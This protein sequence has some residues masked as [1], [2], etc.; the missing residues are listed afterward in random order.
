MV[1]DGWMMGAAVG[2]AIALVYFMSKTVIDNFDVSRQVKKNVAVGTTSVAAL[3]GVWWIFSQP[4]NPPPPERPLAK[5]TV[6]KKSAQP[7]AMSVYKSSGGRYEILL[8]QPVQAASINSNN[9]VVNLAGYEQ[10]DGS[11]SVM[12]CDLP[13]E[14]TAKGPDITLDNGCKNSVAKVHGE[15]SRMSSVTLSGYP[16]REVEGRVPDS[17]SVFK[18]RSYLIGG[19]VYQLFAVGKREWV[20]SADGTKFFE[21]FRPAI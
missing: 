7:A 2:V 1:L 19:R 17:G 8:P 10:P 4:T 18:M 20:L 13:P 15:I 21:S 14:A 16:G 9:M 5:L 3:A 6:Q 11:F 12:Y